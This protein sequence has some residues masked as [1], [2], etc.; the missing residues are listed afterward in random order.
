MNPPDRAARFARLVT[1]VELTLILTRPWTRFTGVLVWIVIAVVA[2]ELTLLLPWPNLPVAITAS[3]LA[4]TL[5]VMALTALGLSW[6]EHRQFQQAR[7]AWYLHDERGERGAY[8]RV[9]GETAELCSVT[10]NPRGQGLGEDL[11][12]QIVS[13]TDGDLTL[14]AV[15]RRV[16]TWYA[17][18]GFHID[19]KGLRGI[20][21]TRPATSSESNPAARS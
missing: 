3:I 15:N 12:R 19:S 8:I 13:E 4:S 11:L 7:Q 14:R 21:M 18:H 17:R 2:A 6:G 5:I 16:A 1:R 10:A 9:R 20:Y